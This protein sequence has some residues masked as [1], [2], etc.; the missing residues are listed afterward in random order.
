MLELD[1]RSSDDG[2]HH[3]VIPQNQLEDLLNQAAKRGAE[4][5]LSKLGLHDENAGKDIQD[6]RSLIEGWRDVKN[7]A[8]RTIVK[9]VIMIILGAISVGTYVNL[10]GGG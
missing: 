1:R 9:W 10:K 5:A 6:L 7:T 4:E 3:L 8:T 2:R